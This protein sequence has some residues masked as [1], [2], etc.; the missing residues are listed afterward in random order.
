MSKINL[1]DLGL[2]EKHLQEA[3][4]ADN[5]YLARV[6]AHFEERKRTMTAAQA[7]KLKIIDMMGS[8]KGPDIQK[9]NRKK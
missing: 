8:L 5:L 9:L 1:Y 6:S 4:M 2:S 3:A 7:E